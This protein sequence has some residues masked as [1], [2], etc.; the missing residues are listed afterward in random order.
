[1][2]EQ[3]AKGILE[4]NG[5]K[6]DFIKICKNAYNLGL[7]TFVYLRLLENKPSPLGNIHVER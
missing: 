3:K 7:G 5:F 4:N 6:G 1:L 2:I